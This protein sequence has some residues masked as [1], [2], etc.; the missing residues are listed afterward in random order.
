MM[1]CEMI[2]NTYIIILLRLLR[3]EQVAA[4]LDPAVGESD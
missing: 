1:G 3:L 4:A 2:E